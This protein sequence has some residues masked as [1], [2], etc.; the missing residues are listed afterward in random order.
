M[1]AKKEGGVKKCQTKFF[2]SNPWFWFF[3]TLYAMLAV[4]VLFWA[5]QEIIW[6]NAEAD[7]Y[8]KL[9]T[10]LT[11][12]LWV[13][14]DSFAKANPDYVLN[15]NF[16]DF[17]DS[18]PSCL[19]NNKYSVSYLKL[20]GKKAIHISKEQR[21]VT[22]VEIA[23]SL[24]FT[25]IPSEKTVVQKNEILHLCYYYVGHDVAE[26][27]FFDN[28]LPPWWIQPQEKVWRFDLGHPN[29]GES[30]ISKF[31]DLLARFKLE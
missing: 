18:C 29:D 5:Y 16:I 21:H 6:R 20:R 9:E 25:K 17:P 31:S 23:I 11:D 15:W 30:P 10:F 28:P 1:N 13:T 22:Q 26:D 8:L 24:S 27:Y 12:S 4:G 3:V 19:N 2:W 7:K 14:A